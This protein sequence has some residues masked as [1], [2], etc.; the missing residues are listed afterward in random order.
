MKIAV[1]NGSPRKE[2]TTAMVEAFR[3]GAEEAGHEVEVCILL[4][5]AIEGLAFNKPLLK[6]EVRFHSMKFSAGFSLSKK[7]DNVGASG[8]FN[9]R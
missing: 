6:P 1:F 3:Q 7:R 2:N 8:A 4:D 9:E 5:D